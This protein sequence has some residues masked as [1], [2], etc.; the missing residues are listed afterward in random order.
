MKALTARRSRQR[1][2]SFLGL[3]FMV[4]LGVCVIA[5]GAKS[6]PVFLEYQAIT[7]AVKKA[8]AEGGSVVDVRNVFD[9]AA[10]IDDISSISGADLIVTKVNERVK[11]GFEYTREIP[12][13]GPAYLL[14]RFKKQAS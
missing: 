5:V 1:G 13:V 3:V 9:R 6:L 2:L 11:V 8:E 10:A 7:K 14:Y 12:L 4:A